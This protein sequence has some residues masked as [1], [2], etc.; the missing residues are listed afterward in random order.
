VATSR[1]AGITIRRRILPLVNTL[2]ASPSRSGGFGWRLAPVLLAL[3]VM[4]LVAGVNFVLDGAWLAFGIRAHDPSGLWPDLLFAPFLHLGLAHLVANTA[5]FAMLGGLIALQSPTR[6]AAVSLAGAVVGGLIV[7][8]LAPAGSVTVG[9]SGL[10]F[11][12]FGW[13]IARAVRERSF[14]AIAV[15]SVALVLYGG[16]LWGL[17]PF[18]LGISWQGH[19]GGLIGGL[20]MARVWPTRAR[21]DPVRDV[22]RLLLSPHPPSRSPNRSSD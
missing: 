10:V 16:I 7:W 18:Q 1:V 22:H 15:G 9:A 20:G 14:M 2:T 12:Y 5:P 21:Q 19:L 6:F 17:S 11:A 4:W 8:V 13:L 3:A